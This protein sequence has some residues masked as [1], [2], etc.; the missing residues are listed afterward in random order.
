MDE[1]Q[2][3]SRQR[4]GDFWLNQSRMH[5]SRGEFSEAA[6]CADK[7]LALNPKNSGA[8]MAR[9]DALGESGRFSEA[10]DCLHRILALQPADAQDWLMR[11]RACLI[12]HRNNDAVSC[13][14]GAERHAVPE[15]TWKEMAGLFSAFR[16]D[17]PARA[18]ELRSRRC[19]G[20]RAEYL[21]E[22]LALLAPVQD[23]GAGRARLAGL[24]RS[25]NACESRGEYEQAIAYYDEVL[26]AAPRLA[27][28]WSQ[29]GTCCTGL[30]DLSR[31]EECFREAIRINPRLTVAWANLGN[32]LGT[33]GMLEEGLA[34]LDTALLLEPDRQYLW[35][36]K[37]NLSAEFRM[38]D[39]ALGYFK[40]A[41]ALDP[42]WALALTNAGICEYH[43]NWFLKAIN[44]LSHALRIDPRSAEAWR[45]KGNCLRATGDIRGAQAC[46]EMADTLDRQ[47]AAGPAATGREQERG[48]AETEG[49]PVFLDDDLVDY[50]ELGRGGFGNVRRGYIPSKQTMVALKTYH[51]HARADPLVPALFRKEAEMWIRLGSHPNI[52]T[53]YG[54]REIRGR[55]FVIMEYIPPDKDGN[56]SLAD[57]IRKG[58]LDPDRALEWAVQICR[59]MEHAF[60]MGLTSHRDLKPANILIGPDGNAKVADFGLAG[61]VHYEKIEVTDYPHLQDPAALSCITLCG[62]GM[63]TVTHMPPEQFEDIG[64]CDE[65]SDIYSFGVLLYEMATGTVPFMAP[66][67]K[68]GSEKEYH[69]FVADMYHLHKHA[70]VPLITSPLYPVIRRCM[71]KD[72]ARRFRNFA[73]VRHALET[74]EPPDQ[75]AAP[76]A[77]PAAVPEVPP[78]PDVR[79]I[80]QQGTALY[81]LKKYR[82]A[83][84]Y[85]SRA[86]EA[87]P[88]SADA[89][90]MAAQCHQ[91]LQEFDKAL[92]AY[93]NVL[94]IAPRTGVAWF[95][96]GVIYL[97]AHEP[98]E[99]IP[100]FEMAVRTGHAPAEAHLNKGM[101]LMML[102]KNEEAI[103]EFKQATNLDPKLK[104]AWNFGA[105]LLEKVEGPAEGARCLEL[106]LREFPQDKEM[107]VNRALMLRKLGRYREALQAVDSALA[108]DPGYQP[109]A[110]LKQELR[111][112]AG[113]K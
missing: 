106:A 9:A 86:I 69:R 71:E 78:P 61:F 49:A 31:A 83:L 48:G 108:I 47:A 100:C 42:E 64:L 7:A 23:N 89:W 10:Q 2:G 6:A 92:E 25:A 76:L 102:D 3:S 88:R 21:A 51:D 56:I 46:Y 54:V 40:E 105:F 30:A 58:P 57:H 4:D 80:I 15:A 41:L 107:W 110:G 39:K 26:G 82:D 28:I 85:F 70:P 77:G 17:G 81:R 79:E 27:S 45:F 43:L 44:S 19:G 1:G 35:L 50:G 112:K 12:L 60:S 38:Y 99:A 84:T 37:G 55:L 59:G 96:R 52:V 74:G 13:I 103:R 62:R 109:A 68:D 5:F 104:R 8:W 97:N 94:D 95:N 87:H 67:R 101:C 63:G 32:L 20:T 16:L 98:E 72:P 34:C 90:L 22:E 14:A 91:N 111:E 75:A 93:G 73:G 53:A 18:C 113:R 33:Q 36:S 11:C 29:K 66:A 24:I 65:R